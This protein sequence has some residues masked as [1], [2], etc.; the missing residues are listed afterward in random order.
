V[1]YLELDPGPFHAILIFQDGRGRPTPQDW[2]SFLQSWGFT[3]LTAEY[4]INVLML[5]D[6]KVVGCYSS[7]PLG[8]KRREEVANGRPDFLAI[9]LG[10]LQAN[11]QDEADT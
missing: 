7:W 4:S 11:E 5:G 6:F 8:N 9:L 1:R 2:G 3:Y 10:P